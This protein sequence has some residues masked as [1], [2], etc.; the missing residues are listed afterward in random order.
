MK[1]YLAHP[2][3]LR[4]KIR[5]IE[6]E[7]EEATG[8]ELLNPFYDTGGDD[9]YE[10]DAGLKDRSHPSLNFINI[11][12]KDLSNVQKCDGIVAYITTATHS[13]GTICE[14]WEAV[15][16]GLPVLIVS[17]DSTMHPWVRYMTTITGGMAFESWDDLKSYLTM[18]E[19]G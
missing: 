14:L 1:Y 13:I 9:I 19:V 11:V 3:P 6:L 2:L 16:M 12:E 4:T 7:I 5:T 18:K 15:R 8:V 10:I 17:P